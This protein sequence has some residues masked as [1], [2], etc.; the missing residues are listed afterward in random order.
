MSLKWSW[1]EEAAGTSRSSEK[2]R[3]VFDRSSGLR[4]YRLAETAGAAD[5]DDADSFPRYEIEFD[6]KRFATG[7][8]LSLLHG[9][10]YLLSA[11]ALKFG[12]LTTRRLHRFHTLR[13]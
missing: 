11:Y 12:H 4:N 1:S 7:P 3:N 9:F 5:V 8:E 13:K 6:D 10:N 2:Y